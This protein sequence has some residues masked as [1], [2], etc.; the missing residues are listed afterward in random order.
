MKEEFNY[1]SDL[2]NSCLGETVCDLAIKNIGR[3]NYNVDVSQRNEIASALNKILTETHVFNRLLSLPNSEMLE[4]FVNKLAENLTT[5][6]S[7]STLDNYSS[8]DIAFRKELVKNAQEKKDKS[9]LT[10][11]VKFISEMHEMGKDIKQ[12]AKEQKIDTSPIFSK[13]ENN[14]IKVNLA[15]RKGKLELAVQ[16]SVRGTL[17]EYNL[18][19]ERQKLQPPKVEDQPRKV[20]EKEKL[21]KPKSEFN[22]IEDV[23]PIPNKKLQPHKPILNVSI[24]EKPVATKEKTE[25]LTYNQAFSLLNQ[26]KERFKGHHVLEGLSMIDVKDIVKDRMEVSGIK[27]DWQENILRTDLAN[28][29]KQAAPNAMKQQERKDHEKDT[30]PS[31]SK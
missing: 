22:E 12:Q 8:K 2:L 18:T 7:V 23:S 27:G 19:Q 3:K 4:N 17:I 25:F 6:L 16:E 21:I 28:M 24:E 1:R 14:Q 26:A 15:K 9:I 10:L 29:I 30:P 13:G 20:D 31:H 11:D 5:G